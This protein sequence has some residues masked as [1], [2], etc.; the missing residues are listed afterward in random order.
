MNE[1]QLRFE[2]IKLLLN[3]GTPAPALLEQAE[4]IYT[5]ITHRDSVSYTDISKVATENPL[6][7]KVNAATGIPVE[8]MR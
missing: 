4:K 1:Q 8:F 7:V 5:W 6:R 3:V 2:V